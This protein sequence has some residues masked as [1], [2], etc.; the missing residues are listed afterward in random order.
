MIVV[1]GRDAFSGRRLPAEPVLPTGDG[2]ERVSERCQHDTKPLIDKEFVFVPGMWFEHVG[3]CDCDD[4]P[5]KPEYDG[6][7]RCAVL[8]TCWPYRRG[9]R[10]PSHDVGCGCTSCVLCRAKPP[11]PDA[12][13]QPRWWRH[14][15]AGVRYGRPTSP[16]KGLPTATHVQCHHCELHL[17]HTGHGRY[18]PCPCRGPRE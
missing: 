5:A 17:V 7:M 4:W 16:D 18:L 2:W 11:L 13:A 15:V 8:R 6:T 9:W 3:S 1:K 10:D 14:W 12:L